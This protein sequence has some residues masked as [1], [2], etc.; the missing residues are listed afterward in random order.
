MYE[1]TSKMEATMKQLLLTLAAT[2]LLAGS[3]LAQA[4]GPGGDKAIAGTPAATQKAASKA[5]GMAGAKITQ[6]GDD[7]PAKAVKAA[8]KSKQKLAT[9]KHKV[10]GAKASK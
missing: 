1:P 4:P 10:E 2:T 7:R 9:D 3:A 6:P 8:S 5:D